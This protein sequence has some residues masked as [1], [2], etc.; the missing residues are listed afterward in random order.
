MYSSYDELKE[1]VKSLVNGEES[2]RSSL[3]FELFEKRGWQK[4]IV[5]LANLISRFD[6]IDYP[7][8]RFEKSA[9]DSLVVL[10]ATNDIYING[11]LLKTPRKVIAL[12]L[13]PIWPTGSRF[14]FI[15]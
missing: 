8:I 4:Y 1:R 5:F 14:K 3:E 7:C 10:K 11:E 2:E 13:N 15:N 9:T 6:S 12:S